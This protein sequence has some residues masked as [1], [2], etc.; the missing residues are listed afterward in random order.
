MGNLCSQLCNQEFTIFKKTRHTLADKNSMIQYEI[1][2]N[3][4]MEKRSHFKTRV[5]KKQKSFSEFIK[6]T[7]SKEDITKIYKFDK[8]ILGEGAFGK[9]SKAYLKRDKSR[10]FAVKT[11][12]KNSQYID[13]SIFLKEVELLKIFDHP[14][15]IKFHEVYEDSK[16]FYLVLEYCEGGDLQKRL[17]KF[18]KFE[19]HEAKKYFWQMLMSIYYIQ[20]RKICHRDLKPE[21]FMFKELGGTQLK[22][23]DFGLSQS[24]F[25]KN[26]MRTI[27]GSPCFVAPEVLDQRYSEKCD[28][29]SLGVILYQMITGRLPF[30][31]ENNREVFQ[32]V[33]EGKYDLDY[34]KQ[35]G[36][37]EECIDM[38]TNMVVIGEDNRI[39]I[40]EA[41]EHPWFGE[42]LERIK[43]LGE[44]YLT[45]NHLNNLIDFSVS[46][47]FQRE[48]I[49]M[50]I[51]AFRDEEEIEK[52]KRIFM[53]INTDCTGQIKRCEVSRLF[54]RFGLSCG[55]DVIEEIIDTLYIREKGVITFLEFEAA[56]IDK[57]FYTDEKRVQTFFNYFDLDKNGYIDKQEIVDCFKRFG[58]DMQDEGVT[59]MIE[60]VDENSDGLISFE[61][62]KELMKGFKL[63]EEAEVQSKF[64]SGKSNMTFGSIG[65]DFGLSGFKE[66]VVEKFGKI[67]KASSKP[68]VISS[69]RSMENHNN[70]RL[71]TRGRSY[72]DLDFRK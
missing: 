18:K 31:S 54:T 46:T 56:L 1:K 41:I 7:R 20:N 48:M 59:M 37:S 70:H 69:H 62:F 43:I 12:K 34:F 67:E 19:E 68:L 35:Q 23:I 26:K 8:K 39:S 60:E 33:Y 2:Q 5:L 38:L 4:K 49:G 32:L 13:L 25:G 52:I 28:V 36:V 55:Q 61:E 45:V 64:K 40:K 71:L 42:T 50:M 58:R 10:I 44:K 51:Q 66:D 47:F 22:L 72:H 30:Y 65:M 15:I 21:N 14:H 53:Y 3:L 6:P 63:G 11:M 27:A 24:F 9:V 17:H 29:W 16:K 57:S